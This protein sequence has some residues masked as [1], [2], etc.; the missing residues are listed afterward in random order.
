MHE[1]T[2]RDT[3]LCTDK[4]TL[5]N[6]IWVNNNVH[7]SAIETRMTGNKSHN[8]MNQSFD[9]NSQGNNNMCTRIA[10]KTKT[11]VELLHNNKPKKTTTNH[12][13]T[14]QIHTEN[15][16]TIQIPQKYH[17]T[18]TKFHTLTVCHAFDTCNV[19]T[20]NNKVRSF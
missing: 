8:E 20:G 6:D 16:N 2:V 5:C 11:E 13:N 9:L 4:D 19:V 3:N 10:E 1:C 17:K 18:T 7:R 12:S 14:T 15:H